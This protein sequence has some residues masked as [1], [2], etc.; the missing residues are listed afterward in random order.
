MTTTRSHSVALA[1]GIR[2]DT[3]YYYWPDTW[4]ND[5]PG[6]FTGSGMPMR[7]A[8]RDGTMVD[9]YQATEPDDR[10]VGSVVPVHDRHIA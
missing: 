10:R 1:N 8:K 3:N 7:F 4:V 6:V 9:V 5:V 2:F